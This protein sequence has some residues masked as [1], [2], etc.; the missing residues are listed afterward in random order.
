MLASVAITLIDR[1]VS[2]AATLVTCLLPDGSLEES[3]AAL[4]TDGPV[5]SS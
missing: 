5:M 3:L 4:A 1:T 2:G